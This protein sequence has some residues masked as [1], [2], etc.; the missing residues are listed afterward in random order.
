MAVIKIQPLV[1]FSFGEK[2]M[3]IKDRIFRT[4]HKAQKK[5]NGF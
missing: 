5:K 2:R 1:H 4:A 3:R